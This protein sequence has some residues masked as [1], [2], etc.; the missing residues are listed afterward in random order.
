[1]APLSARVLRNGMMQLKPDTVVL[2]GGAAE[3][4]GH[5]DRIVLDPRTQLVT[6]LVVRKSSL[7]LED[8]LLPVDLVARISEDRIVLRDDLRNLQDLPAFD[9]GQFVQVDERSLAPR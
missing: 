9:A 7:L 5:L 3:I 2:T 6:H 1:M 4:V 8:K